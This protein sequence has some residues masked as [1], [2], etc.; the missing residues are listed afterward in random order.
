[1]GAGGAGVGAGVAPGSLP[2]T[3]PWKLRRPASEVLGYHVPSGMKVQKP[4]AGAMLA[5][6]SQHAPLSATLW[7]DSGWTSL[8]SKSVST[9]DGEHV[10]ALPIMGSATMANDQDR[11]F[12]TECIIKRVGKLSSSKS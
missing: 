12:C 9:S 1:M 5:Q 8:P 7:P 11:I 4:Q 3:Y 6:R 10:A 2:E